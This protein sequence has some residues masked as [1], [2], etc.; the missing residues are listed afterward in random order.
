MPKQLLLPLFAIA[1]IA[2]SGAHAQP[3]WGATPGQW[4][5]MPV[6]QPLPNIVQHQH[7]HQHIIQQRQIMQQPPVMQQQMQRQMFIPP[8]HHRW[9]IGG[10]VNMNFMFFEEEHSVSTNWE[11]DT[12][13]HS[14]AA[15]TGFDF[16]IGHKLNAN[17]RGEVEIGFLT[18]SSF[19]DCGPNRAGD[20][21]CFTFR[22]STPY[23]S[24][25]FTYNT[26]E[27]S[28]GW[29]YAGIGIGAALPSRQIQGFENPY[30]G[31]NFSFMPSL[32]AGYRVRVADNW[33]ADIGYRFFMYD[34]GTVEFPWID[35]T[36]QSL[37]RNNIG[38]IMNHSFRIGLVYEF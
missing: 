4:M 15:Q 9:Y 19:A 32:M 22:T 21:I 29:V 7:S 12:V 18:E 35:N 36:E 33:F 37:F 6:Q 16:F 14:A 17:W 38:W 25:N 26:I 13:R 11:R 5:P 1:A 24:L 23:A 10:R 8:A 27:Q 34:A 20:T 31:T 28:W 3:N 30:S 2:A